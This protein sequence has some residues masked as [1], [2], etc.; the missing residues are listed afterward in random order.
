[1]LDRY[2]SRRLALVGL[3]R[4]RIVALD[5]RALGGAGRALYGRI[6]RLLA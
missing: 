6:R 5:R 4:E 2:L 3:S 1:M